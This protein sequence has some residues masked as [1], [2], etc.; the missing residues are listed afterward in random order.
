[1]LGWHMD[2]LR[3]DGRVASCGVPGRF[4]LQFVVID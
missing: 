2:M 1:V 4:A 3:G